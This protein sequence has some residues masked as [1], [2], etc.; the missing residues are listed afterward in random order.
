MASTRSSA[1]HGVSFI[2]GMDL[3]I[4]CCGFMAVEKP[5]FLKVLDSLCG[6]P[7]WKQPKK[8]NRD[9]KNKYQS[10]ICVLRKFHI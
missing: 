7:Q 4:F 10:W 5:C 9:E 6:Y 3:H 2:L 8:S 1:V